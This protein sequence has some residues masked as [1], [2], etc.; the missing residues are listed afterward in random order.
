[1]IRTRGSASARGWGRVLVA[2]VVA[3]VVGLA[4]CGTSDESSEGREAGEAAQSAQGAPALSAAEKSQARDAL[5]RVTT[6]LQAL[7]TAYAS[8]NT[9]EAQADFDAAKRDWDAVSP[10]ISAREAREAQLLFDDLAAK[11]KTNAP[12][13][14]IGLVARGLAGELKTDIGSQLK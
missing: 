9:A 10:K 4:A 11:L 14:E 13:N 7:D 1:M 3:M 12:A 5:A 6:S 2:V 8:G